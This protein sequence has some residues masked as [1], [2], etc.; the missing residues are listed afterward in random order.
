MKITAL[1]E[2]ELIQEVINTSGAKNVTEALRIALKDYLARRKLLDLAKE[3]AAE[4]IEFY[5]GADQL[6][7][8]NQR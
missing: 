2:D 5:Y 1:I 3:V 4:P 8:Q 6:R 7:D